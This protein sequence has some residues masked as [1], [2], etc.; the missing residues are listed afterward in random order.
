MVSRWIGFVILAAA[1]LIVG[2]ATILIRP[3]SYVADNQQEMISAALA[4]NKLNDA[5][6]ENVNQQM[7]VNGW[8]ARDLLAINARQNVALINAATSSLEL[9][10]R[11]N[12]VIQG[13]LVLMVLLIGA[14]AGVG[15]RLT[16][17]MRGPKPASSETP[18]DTGS[19]QVG[20]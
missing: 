9:Q 11:T 6:A 3:S 4:D 19:D 14:V 10:Q 2:L 12:G 15:I 5:N 13:V 17:G 1:A 16:Q 20:S 7:V 18:G 8:V